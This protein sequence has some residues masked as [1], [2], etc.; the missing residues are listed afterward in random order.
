MGQSA[1]GPGGFRVCVTGRRGVGFVSVAPKTAAWA[2]PSIMSSRS[3]M[4]A[5]TFHSEACCT[6]C[7]LRHLPQ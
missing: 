7:S 5:T 3:L 6:A 2:V 1:Y 4:V